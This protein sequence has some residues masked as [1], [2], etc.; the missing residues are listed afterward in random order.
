MDVN[1]TFTYNRKIPVK[2]AAFSVPI[3]SPPTKVCD[4]NDFETDKSKHKCLQSDEKVIAKTLMRK[5]LKSIEIQLVKASQF[6][7]DLK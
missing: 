4:E 6:D 7:A 3:S 5:L 2:L 1:Q